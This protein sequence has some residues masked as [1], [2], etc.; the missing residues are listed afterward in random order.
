MCLCVSVLISVLGEDKEQA[1]GA[2]ESVRRAM[3]TT[4]ELP[5]YAQ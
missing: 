5:S 4:V 1:R 3:A 2:H